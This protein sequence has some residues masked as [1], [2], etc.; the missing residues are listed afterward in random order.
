MNMFTSNLKMRKAKAI[1]FGLT[2]G[3]TCVGCK[4]ACYAQKGFY[5]VHA[6]NCVAHWEYNVGLAM[7]A[8]F[9]FTLH[10]ELLKKK[11]RLVRIHTEGDFF[12][13][14]YLDDW[15]TVARLFPN[16]QFY[17]YTKALQLDWSDLPVNFK[18]IQSIGGEYDS[19]IDYS[20]PHARIFKT[21]DE[22]AAAG[23]LDAFDD[24]T[25]AADPST[26]KIGLVAH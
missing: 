18:R 8:D 15:K 24:D 16:K 22:L 4:V 9:V 21:A 17:C 7:S 3:M 23:Y 25:V 6:K 5:Q 11:A 12:S 19:L 14:R 10:A 1:G 2:P 20:E 26:V 13:Q